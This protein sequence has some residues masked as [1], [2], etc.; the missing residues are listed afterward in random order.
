MPLTL[1]CTRR[2]LF[3]EVRWYIYQFYSATWVIFHGVWRAKRYTCTCTLW[4][5]S[6]VYLHN[7]QWVCREV[8]CGREALG[9]SHLLSRE[10][11]VTGVNRQ[12]SEACHSKWR[13]T[14]PPKIWRQ[15]LELLYTNEW[16][17]ST[18]IISMLSVRNLDN[19]AASAFILVVV[20]YSNFTSEVICF[21]C[22]YSTFLISKK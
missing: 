1:N 9:N 8:R 16:Q 3:T 20:C 4:R 22:F 12:E 18:G 14:L 15:L 11:L 13:L 6:F 7:F 10:S 17:C 21:F 5:G 2:T 19:S